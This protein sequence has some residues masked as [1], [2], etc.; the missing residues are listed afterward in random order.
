MKTG[1]SDPWCE[2]CTCGSDYGLQHKRQP[3]AANAGQ[4]PRVRHV[5]A[6]LTVNPRLELFSPRAQ[7]E[8][9]CPRAAML[10]VQH[11]VVLRD[12]IGGEE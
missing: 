4:M 2:G 12:R 8:L 3:C 7:V 6:R 10:P 9:L 1:R 5:L 11:D